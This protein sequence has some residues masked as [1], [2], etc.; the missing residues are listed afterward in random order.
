MAI[1]SV[2]AD[3]MNNPEIAQKMVDYLESHSLPVPKDTGVVFVNYPKGGN[4]V[5]VDI[6]WQENKMVYQLKTNKVPLD[7]LKM[8]VS[9][10]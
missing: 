9:V 3:E 4:S 5:N 6:R 7:A 2:S 8:T 1:K 10:K